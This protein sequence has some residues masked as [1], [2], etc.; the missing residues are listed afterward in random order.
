M[1][2]REK[3]IQ[4]E[5]RFMLAHAGVRVFQHSVWPCHVCGSRPRPQTGLGAYTADLICV[6][7][8]FGRFCAIEVKTPDKRNAKRDAPQREWAEWVR[9]FGG[10]A[11]VATNVD[12]AYALIEQ[13]RELP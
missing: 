3:V 8:P 2:P 5:I 9:R 12:E 7:R 11:G 6:A 4:E 10:V 13:A 1:T